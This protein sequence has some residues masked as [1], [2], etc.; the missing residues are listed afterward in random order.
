MTGKKWLAA[1]G[2]LLLLIQILR[3]ER[4]NPASD[5][6][7]ALSQL[8]SPPAEIELTLKNACLDCHSNQTVWPWYSEVAP[9]SWMIADH[10]KRGRAELNFS[11]WGRY[12]SGER[13]HLL[14]EAQEL[15]EKREMPPW[16]YRLFHP[17]ARL[18][19]AEIAALSQWAERERASLEAAGQQT[20]DR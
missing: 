1:A 3:P 9:L 11:E 15:L 18:S 19:D 7:L 20:A 12:Q 16:G 6:S 10:V 2:G 13:A 17:E 5:S 14:K 8:A 4:T